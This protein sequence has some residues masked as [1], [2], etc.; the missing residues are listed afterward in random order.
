MRKFF[1]Y[2]FWGLLLV[3]GYFSTTI[4]AIFSDSYKSNLTRK[5]LTGSWIL[6][7]HNQ[8][9]KTA[10]IGGDGNLFSFNKYFLFT[11]GTFFPKQYKIKYISY[12]INGKL[13]ENQAAIILSNSTR[14]DEWMGNGYAISSLSSDTLKL[15]PTY[16]IIGSAK[17]SVYTFKKVNER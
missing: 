16:M 4:M 7:S 5:N 8:Y 3:G 14:Y 11:K 13:I 17:P 12:I 2:F 10:F 15:V 9:A 1:F 6:V